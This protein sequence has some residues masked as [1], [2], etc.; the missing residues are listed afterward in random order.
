MNRFFVYEEYGAKY[1]SMIKDVAIIHRAMPEWD[2]YQ[3]GL[4]ALAASLGSANG[5]ED[6]SRRALTVGDLLVKVGGVSITSSDGQLTAARPIQ[7]MCKYPLLFAELLKH[8]PVC[9]C[10][11]SYME[12]ESALI[13]LREATG[14]INRATDND[15]TKATLEKSWLLQDRLV[16]PDQVRGPFCCPYS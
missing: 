15:R 4:E 2:K 14:A 6:Q 13:R 1:E 11:Y 3:K 10:P 9:D 5:S 7:R 16:F 8:T 12:I